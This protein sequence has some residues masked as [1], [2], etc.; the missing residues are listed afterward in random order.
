MEP[1]AARAPVNVTVSCRSS[2][3][4]VSVAGPQF[5]APN[6]ASA[7]RPDNLPQE[8]EEVRQ[9][10]FPSPGPCEGATAD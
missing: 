2:A 4:R 10:A 9:V 1:S 6:Q 3:F 7:S 5:D 8:K